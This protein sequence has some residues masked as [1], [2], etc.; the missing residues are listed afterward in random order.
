MNATVHMSRLELVM[1]RRA[2][3]IDTHMVDRIVAGGLTR[4]FETIGTEAGTYRRQD[5]QGTW[6]WS[7]PPREPT[8]RHLAA[9]ESLATDVQWIT[10]DDERISGHECLAYQALR[11]NG[12]DAWTQVLLWVAKD[13]LRPVEMLSLSLRKGTPF[14]P[15][16]PPRSQTLSSQAVT[17][18][19]WDDPA[20]SIPP[21]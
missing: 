2:Q 14:D 1:V 3:E 21:M 7:E 11:G 16:N 18:S 6:L 15:A 5:L 17:W 9:L 8:D 10:L 19:N 20:L 12:Y 4:Y 13:S